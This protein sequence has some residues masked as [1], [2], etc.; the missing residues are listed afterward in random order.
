MPPPPPPAVISNDPSWFQNA[1]ADVYGHKRSSDVAVIPS[2]A[3]A[4]SAT[5]ASDS[6]LLRADDSMLKGRTPQPLVEESTIVAL[7]ALGSSKGSEGRKSDPKEVRR[8]SL[9]S[10]LLGRR[11]PASPSRRTEPKRGSIGAALGLRPR[12]PSLPERAAPAQHR[13]AREGRRRSLRA[14][15][16]LLRRRLSGRKPPGPPAPATPAGAAAAPAAEAGIAQP[17][18]VLCSVG[19]AAMAAPLALGAP[20]RVGARP[21]G[22]FR[23][24]PVLGAPLTAYTACECFGCTVPVVVALL[25]AELAQHPTASAD[26]SPD[27]LHKEGLFRIASDPKAQQAAERQIAKGRLRSGHTPEVLANLLKAFVR[28]VPNGLLGGVPL[29]AVAECT[30]AEGGARLLAA[31]A[32]PERAL[33]QWL[34]RVLVEVAL[35]REHNK[36]G[37]SNLVLVFAPNL[38]GDPTCH[39]GKGGRLPLDPMLEFQRV[40]HTSNALHLLVTHAARAMRHDSGG[41]APAPAVP[42]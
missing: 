7:A 17:E 12:Q 15:L 24:A 5:T 38:L 22:G 30:S 16:G 36:M 28:R 18:L 26:G 25:W 20:F 9:A 32:P 14:S 42:P 6:S 23:R 3:P 10:V 2:A 1:A 35:R 31:L 11:S 34:V 8:S 19:D 39:V 27:G 29:E 40:T 13:T 37:V 41:P 21:V 33:L 4:I